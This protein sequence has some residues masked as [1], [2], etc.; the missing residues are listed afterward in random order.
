MPDAARRDIRVELSLHAFVSSLHPRQRVEVLANG[1]PVERQTLQQAEVPAFNL[2]IPGD[3]IGDDGVVRLEFD[4]PDAVSPASLGLSADPR[5]L[6]IGI[7][8]L[9]VSFAGN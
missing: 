4:C 8:R 9:R 5:V 2:V 7:V 6:S 3:A 1:T